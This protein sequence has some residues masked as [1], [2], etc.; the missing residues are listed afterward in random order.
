MRFSPW[1]PPEIKPVHV[2]VYQVWNSRIYAYWNGKKWCWAMRSVNEAKSF[3]ITDGADQYKEWR[4][5]AEK[6]D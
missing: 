2:G 6:P 4:G 5:L 3:R 1:F